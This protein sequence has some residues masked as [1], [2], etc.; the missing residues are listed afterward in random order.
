M[1]Y[2]MVGKCKFYS[3]LTPGEEAEYWQEVQKSKTGGGVPI[4]ARAMRP[5]SRYRVV[6]TG[7]QPPA[8]PAPAAPPEDPEG[9]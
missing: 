7:D 3:H 9:E 4:P 1:P 6:S 5:G 2:K 8:A